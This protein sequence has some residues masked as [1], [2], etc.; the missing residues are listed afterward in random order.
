VELVGHEDAVELHRGRREN[1]NMT[2]A[3]D[4]AQ[5]YATHYDVA[6]SW[7]L[8]PG[9]KVM[10]GDPKKRHC[11]F[12]GKRPPE[13][14]FRKVAHAIPEALGNKSIES[15]YE[16]DACNEMFGNGIENDL[17][18]WSKPI[19]TFARIRG[20]SGVP[21]LKKGGDKGWRIEHDDTGFHVKSYED[22]PLFE[23]DEANKTITF[24]LKRDPYT[25][26]AVLKAFMKIGLTLL[27]EDEVENFPHLMAW[28][29][30]LD[31]TRVFA[32]QCPVLY[33]FQPGP[34]PNDLIDVYILRRKPDVSGCLYA[35]L[36]LGYGNE[37]FQV[38]LPSQKHDAATNGQAVSIYRFPAPGSPEPER[39][40]P[41][42][43]GNL[44]LT[45]RDLVRGESFTLVTGYE[46]ATKTIS[47]VAPRWGRLALIASALAL[48]AWCVK[49]V[50][51]R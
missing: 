50:L 25:P 11:R 40:G 48:T 24:K 10:L 19:R 49:K 6:C 9:N 21:T 30:D 29:R 1:A 14:T 41:P 46:Q 17:G 2:S 26:V 28:V 23:I 4:A 5:F 7:Q 13:A 47:R 20:K 22:D 34:M 32:D 27:P 12:C 35:F 31:H 43:V 38:P 51:D 3:N 33:T 37:M 8:R 15:A 18:N 42:R 45:S 39:Y 36:V 44:N 16:C